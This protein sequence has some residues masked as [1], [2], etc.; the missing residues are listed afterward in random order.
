MSDMKE[1][2]NFILILLSFNFIFFLKNGTRKGYSWINII[3][4]IKNT[5]CAFKLFS[6]I[7]STI[8]C[9]MRAMIPITDGRSFT[10]WTHVIESKTIESLFSIDSFYNFT[11]FKTQKYSSQFKKFGS[12]WT[13]N[14]KQ[15][16]CFTI[17]WF[18]TSSNFNFR[19]GN[20]V[21]ACYIRNILNNLT[22][23]DVII[24]SQ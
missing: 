3:M 19:R 13:K 23:D 16:I 9:A 12:S 24:H 10:I 1:S 17:N 18:S 11:S 4:F 21:V 5:V 7:K 20:E 15:N 14:K 6:I 2:A 8:S 22:I